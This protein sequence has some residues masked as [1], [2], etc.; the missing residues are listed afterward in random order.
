MND[1]KDFKTIFECLVNKFGGYVNNHSHIDR[2]YTLDRKYLEHKSMDPLE[3][4]SY[5]LK[6][7]QNLTGD[8]HN[9][10]AYETESLEERMRRVLDESIEH[11]ISSITSFIDTTADRVGLS[12]LEIALKLKKE[13]ED[14]IKLSTVSYPI[15]GFKPDDEKRHEVFREASKLSDY[16]GGLPE[17]DEPRDH[18]GYDEHL[19]TVLQ[20][21]IELN[22]EV[23]VHVDQAN[24]PFEEGT[25]TL[26]Q[27][28]RWL[29]IPKLYD[30]NTPSVWAVH[31]ISPSCYSEEKFEKVLDG[32]KKYNIG[33]IV[34]PSAAI[35]MRQLRPVKTP[36]HNSIARVLEMLESKIPVRIG[37]DN[38]SDV[39]M[40]SNTP[41]MYY[42]VWMLANSVR[43]Y[44]PE[45]LAKI[46]TNTRLNDMDRELISKSLNQD[47]KVW[48]KFIS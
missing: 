41:D 17:R 25:L 45:I 27:A 4:S 11:N 21:G 18:I 40:P 24:N 15:F 22:K 16:I 6:V 34:C 20:T 7:K 48:T 47:R 8:L 2:A 43:F 42:E 13:Y 12:A 19:K 46:A 38:I 35:S 39:F 28:V 23:H 3:A 33:V 29:G 36:T 10:P 31:S 9:G 44:N 1:I 5:S 26:I 37:T 14:K 32:L 30:D